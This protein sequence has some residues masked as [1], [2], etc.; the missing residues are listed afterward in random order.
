MERD[1]AESR[2][3]E[4]SIKDSSG[5]NEDNPREEYKL[6]FRRWLILAVSSL[7]SMMSNEIWISLS[8]VASIV[9]TYYQVN[10]IFI[11]WLALVSSLLMV[12]LLVPC[13]YFLTK[14]GLRW[15]MII[16]AILS[17]L[18]SCLRL[19]G[20]G[21][22]GFAYVF[23]GSCICALAHCLLFFLPPHVAMV[24]FG[25]RERTIASS[26]G[27]L[28]SASGVGVGYLLGIFFVSRRKGEEKEIGYGI[29]NLL[30]F[31][32]IT[33]TVLFH[34]CVVIMRDAP[35]TP[36][37]RS[38]GI[39]STML[40]VDFDDD[41]HKT[42]S[43]VGFMQLTSAEYGGIL[44]KDKLQEGLLQDRLTCYYTFQEENAREKAARAVP[45]FKDSLMVLLKQKQ[46]HILCK[47]YAIY[48]GL[49]FTYTTIFNQITIFAFPGKEKEIG[50]MGF[51][52]LMSGL[53]SMFLCGIFLSRTREYRLYSRVEFAL[54]AVSTLI[55]TMALHSGASLEMVFAL[56]VIY[57]L[58]TYPYMSLGL[59]YI[60]E[61][62]YPVPEI[63]S[64]SISILLASLYSIVITQVIGIQFN[65]GINIGGYII[66]GLYAL[67]FL[68]VM[69]A[70]GSLRRSSLDD[71]IETMEGYSMLTTNGDEETSYHRK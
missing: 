38:Q 59:E 47:A 17:A 23:T 52:V 16:G 33:N 64:S 18:G 43:R 69:M 35:P 41:A 57:G 45:S 2:N 63:L 70:N 1:H 14:F 11:D 46:F 62:T 27:M 13:S 53:L 10:S 8:T 67:G 66:S 7:I 30:M 37:S 4:Q 44:E 71:E 54:A 36:P 42:R 39:R 32:A 34:A 68:L 55:L 40:D 3:T 12:L 9:H 19:V 31:E 5:A 60:A 49:R 22:S 56:Y 51:A 61:I 29:R 58:F 15:S 26:I 50:Y 24:W 20:A 28:V 48:T 21:S 6:Y 25:D 65:S